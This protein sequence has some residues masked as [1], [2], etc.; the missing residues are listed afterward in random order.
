MEEQ[1]AGSLGSDGAP[2]W[3]GQQRVLVLLVLDWTGRLPCWDWPV[4]CAAE[5]WGSASP[6]WGLTEGC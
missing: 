2:G 4:G 5:P 1:E 6:R 3:A